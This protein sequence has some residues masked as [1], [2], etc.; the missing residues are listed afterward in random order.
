[1][2][3]A[4]LSLPL[5]FSLR[6]RIEVATLGL[7]ARPKRAQMPVEKPQHRLLIP[8][9]IES[10]VSFQKPGGDACPGAFPVG[11]QIDHHHGEPHAM[12]IRS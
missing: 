6:S 9:R 12:M 7:A 3:I 4:F 10:W 2:P 1:L 8:R 11:L 5:S